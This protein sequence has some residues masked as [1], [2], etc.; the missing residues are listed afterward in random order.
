MSS[1]LSI[2][3]S[4]K[5]KF[6]YANALLMTSWK[7]LILTKLKN[8]FMGSLFLRYSN[9]LR[10]LLV[11]LPMRGRSFY[12]GITESVFPLIDAPSFVSSSSDWV[13]KSNFLAFARVVYNLYTLLPNSLL[14]N[15]SLPLARGN[16]VGVLSFWELYD[17]QLIFST[18]IYGFGMLT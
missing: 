15:E 4:K 8:S 14:V 12:Y 16:S 10:S 5:Y 7:Q 3:R 11:K 17:E 13:N 6:G 1:A 9:S 18:I 2:S